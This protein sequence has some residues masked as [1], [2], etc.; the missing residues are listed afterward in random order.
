MPSVLLLNQSLSHFNF[1]SEDTNRSGTPISPLTHTSM[2]SQGAF[3]DLDHTPREDDEEIDL[4]DDDNEDSEEPLI[5]TA[6]DSAGGPVKRK[7][8]TSW[9][10]NHCKKT[11]TK[12]EA[13]CLVCNTLVWYSLDLSTNMLARHIERRH[14]A[15]FAAHLKDKFN[16]DES[17]E[18][19][20]NKSKITSTT[21][22]S[23]VKDVPKF[24]ASLVAFCVATYQSYRIC[25]EPTFRDLIRSLN[26]KAP[27]MSR[28]KLTTL[29]KEEY[30]RNLIKIKAILKG[31]TFALTTDAWTSISLTGY[32][33]CT[34]HFIDRVTWTLHSIVFGLWEKDG[35]SKA[36]DVY[37]YLASQLSSFDVVLPQCV[38]V[39]TD[40][41]AT[42]IAA[43]RLIMNE[44]SRLGGSTK[45][46]GC[47]DHLLELVTGIA[48]NDIQESA[49]TLRACRRLVNFFNSSSQAMAKLLA[50]QE[51]GMD[52]RPIQ[53]VETRWWSTHSML[54][55]LL[56]LKMYLQLL[57]EEGQLHVNLNNNQWL[58]VRDLCALLKPFMA[59][60]KL[61][62]GQTYVTISFVPYI[63]YRIRKGLVLANTDVT[64]S[65][66]VVVTTTHMLR[67]FNA[68]FGTGDDGSVARAQLPEGINRRPMGIHMLALMAAFLDP[69]LKGGVGISAVDVNFIWDQIL[70]HAVDIAVD[71]S[72]HQDPPPP[73]PM[74]MAQP[75]RAIARNVED[76]DLFDELNHHYYQEKNARNPAIPGANNNNNNNNDDD[77]AALR[78]RC[79][80][81]AR[82][83]LTLYKADP[84]IRLHDD[85]G[86]YLDP[87]MWWKVNDTK[88]KVLSILAANVLCI[89]ATSAP[90]ERVFS[91]AG[92]TIANDRARLSS[93]N[94]NELIFLH[95][96]IP[97]IKKWEDIQNKL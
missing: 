41:E 18:G 63:L 22:M 70:N 31:R 17:S 91:C 81:A 52:V 71:L 85:D 60:Q 95:D 43:G 66:N 20:T 55:R 7:K 49:G 27:E 46:I 47:I 44:S 15:V 64:S 50:K 28:A 45:W 82:A 48:F 72:D 24:E 35:A 56:R 73:H 76:I 37:N 61:L 67:A 29:V 97:T 36:Q 62:E 65:V 21:I 77:A 39:V 74:Q 25:E 87:L 12:G 4:A 14:P 53:D 75:P 8:I 33:T 51:R 5:V 26:K 1:I 90:S 83:E 32:V 34:C 38:A 10:W 93:G 23:W 54:A 69:R 79:V 30:Q 86:K 2:T 9:V 94:A 57:E 78:A 92:L 13:L 16:N 42:M 59:A 3:D 89:P 6:H 84:M 80:N 58:I 68:K 19:G 11:D 40:T 88:Y 96:A